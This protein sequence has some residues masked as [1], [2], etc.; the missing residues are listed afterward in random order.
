[1]SS[2]HGD[3]S[4]ISQYMQQVIDRQKLLI[5]IARETQQ[6]HDLHHMRSTARQNGEIT[7]FPVNSYVLFT[8]PE[9]RKDK[10]QP[11][12]LGPFR[13][14]SVEGSKYTIADLISHRVRRVHVS[15]LTPFVY[16]EQRSS[17]AE[18]ATADRREFFVE[19][20]I[21]HKGSP[22]KKLDMHF[23]VRWVG[24]G[25]EADAWEPYK[26]VR[27]TAALHQYLRDNKLEKLI[28]P[29]FRLQLQPPAVDK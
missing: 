21:G 17:P 10:F 8:P 6:K 7:S 1:M 24:Y 23:H 25:P 2:S 3:E 22:K 27:T 12:K 18:A 14:V 11:R 9:G 26:N 15:Q 4:Q 29:R 16:D 13:V 20:I 28:A 5:E 19:R